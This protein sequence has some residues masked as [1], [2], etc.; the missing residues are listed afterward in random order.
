[1]TLKDRGLNPTTISTPHNGRQ[2]CIA[3]IFL[4]AHRDSIQFRSKLLRNDARAFFA[5]PSTAE[6]ARLAEIEKVLERI[7]I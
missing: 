6:F 3:A 2:L 5:S 1:M 7:R 4:Q